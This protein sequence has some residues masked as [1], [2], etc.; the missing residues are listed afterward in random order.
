M[1]IG[2][3]EVIN[4]VKC[5]IKHFPWWNQTSPTR[6]P[7]MLPPFFPPHEPVC[8]PVRTSLGHSLLL[9]SACPL[10]SLHLADTF[11]PHL[12]TH[13]LLWHDFTRGHNT[14]SARD[15]TSFL[16]LSSFSLYFLSRWQN[17]FLSTLFTA[18]YSYLVY[19]WETSS[20][21]NFPFML[22]LNNK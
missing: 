13:H 18:S 19:T 9:A 12:Y 17:M 10:S 7:W 20:S 14:T 2:Q 3:S 1:F 21:I 16:D 22:S 15:S 4:F 5:S 11:F 6:T 8:E